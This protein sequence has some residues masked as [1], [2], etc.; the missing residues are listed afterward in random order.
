MDDPAVAPPADAKKGT[1]SFKPNRGA[2][3]TQANSTNYEASP[4]EENYKNHAFSGSIG[5]QKP[6]NKSVDFTVQ[7]F[8]EQR[9]S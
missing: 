1:P 9:T 3:P 4:I 2:S 5:S 6:M 7:K 8:S